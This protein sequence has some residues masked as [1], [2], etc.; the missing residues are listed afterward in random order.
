MLGRGG[1]G[2]LCGKIFERIVCSCLFVAR[3][4]AGFP[5]MY[6]ELSAALKILEN[7]LFC[8][9]RSTKKRFNFPYFDCQSTIK[10]AGNFTDKTAEN[11]MQL[12]NVWKITNLEQNSSKMM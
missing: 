7:F 5:R 11:I 6:A 2:A 12:I 1:G 10:N 9:L 8:T 4:R 3:L